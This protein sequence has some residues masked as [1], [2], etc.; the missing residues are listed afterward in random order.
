MFRFP[1]SR[2]LLRLFPLASPWLAACTLTP[3]QG[4]AGSTNSPKWQQHQRAVASITSYQTRGAFAWLSGSKKVYARFNWQQSAPDHYR[5]LLT[6]PLGST[7]LQLTVQGNKA[8]L[9]DNKGQHYSDNNAEKILRQL[10]GMAIPID[11]LR[12]WITGLPGN[13]TEYSLDDKY[14]LKT[15]H[16]SHNGQEWTVTFNRYDTAQDPALPSLLELS[17]GD[18]R[19]KLR[20]DSWS[21]K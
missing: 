9:I 17:S 11:N 21:I 3:H 13:A 16:Y 6:S 12:Q 8:E 19:L 4:P 20:M 2:C 5:L 14:Q 7:E 1:L 15:A 18:N 10:T